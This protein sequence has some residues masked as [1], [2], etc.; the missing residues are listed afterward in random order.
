MQG[1]FPAKKSCINTTN[2]MSGFK[3]SMVQDFK[4]QRKTCSY[5]DEHSYRR[6]S[7]KFTRVLKIDDEHSYRSESIKLQEC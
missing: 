4:G 3:N 7:I 5:K 1:S 2:T 6:E